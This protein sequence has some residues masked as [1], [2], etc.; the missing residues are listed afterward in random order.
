[1]NS[2]RLQLIG[3]GLTACAC[4]FGMLH[5]ERLAAEVKFFGKKSAN[6]AAVANP[7]A[8]DAQ[9]LSE[10][11]PD[12]VSPPNAA[13]AHAFDKSI[14]LNYLGKTWDDVLRDVARQSGRS[15]VMDKTPPGRF[16][17]N[18]WKTYSLH[19]ALRILNGELEPK[20]FRLLERGPV[21]DLIFLRD[22]RQDY[23]RP[24]LDVAHTSREQADA[25]ASRNDEPQPSRTQH[26][27]QVTSEP[28]E[29]ARS[30]F[31]NETA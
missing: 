6:P 11:L 30:S 22:A 18:D 28:T 9:L 16:S 2:R 26:R 14:K 4:A 17:R 15:L 23:S 3:V 25:E 13:S 10:N 8:R 12:N 27:S 5:A 24:V 20:G 31:R 29:S 19:D 21:L 1:M 7:N